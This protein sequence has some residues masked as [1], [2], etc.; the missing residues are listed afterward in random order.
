[1]ARMGRIRG[2]TIASGTSGEEPEGVRPDARD[3]A[4]VEVINRVRFARLKKIARG[5]V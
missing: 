1:M 4:Y 2:V 5:H 3:T